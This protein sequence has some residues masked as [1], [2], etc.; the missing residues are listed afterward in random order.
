MSKFPTMG[1]DIAK[2]SATIYDHGEEHFTGT[3][4]AG[5]GQ[6]VAGVL[7]RPEQTA[8]RFVRTMSI[9]TSQR[10]LL[11]AFEKLTAR[12][13]GVHRRSTRDLMEDG[14]RM[15]REGDGGWR[16]CLV[17]AQLYDEGEGRGMLAAT[18]GESDADLLGVAAETAEQVV[19][20]ALELH[21]AR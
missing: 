11:G 12:K 15:L 9:E 7:R 8:N 14:R 13:W 19:L 17:V 10:E 21:Q 1:F 4:L 2:T 16:L 3:T 5:I 18:R 6:S 20:K